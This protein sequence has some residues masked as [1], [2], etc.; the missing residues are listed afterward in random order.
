MQ[1]TLL[2]AIAFICACGSSSSLDGPTTGTSEQPLAC[3]P[4]PAFADDPCAAASRYRV[5][6]VAADVE[7]E[8]ATGTLKLRYHNA[9][10]TAPWAY[11]T[12]RVTAD[13]DRV[14]SFAD[15]P[16][17]YVLGTCKDSD[18]IE[19]SFSIASPM[20]SGTT[21]HLTLTPGIID[22]QNTQC[23]LVTTT[24]QVVVP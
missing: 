20:T 6:A 16:D 7:G 14:G 12:V 1:T 19:R 3:A 5:E 8:G 11:P 10:T 9:S 17:L 24:L 23:A 18:V 4:T 13:D 15:G 22:E 2:L 21:F